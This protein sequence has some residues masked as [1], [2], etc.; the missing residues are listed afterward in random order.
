M[1]TTKDLE[2]YTYEHRQQFTTTTRKRNKN[3]S[4]GNPLSLP[5]ARQTA[6]A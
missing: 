3:T 1:E 5:E 6:W 4:R 2:K